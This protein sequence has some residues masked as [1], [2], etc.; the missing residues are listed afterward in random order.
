MNILRSGLILS[1]FLAGLAIGDMSFARPAE[2]QAQQ[3]QQLTPQFYRRNCMMCHKTAVPEG[4]DPSI[5]AGVQPIHP[6]RSRDVMPDTKCWRRCE[7]CWPQTAK[8]QR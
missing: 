6:T 3:A 5:V 8:S 7:K 2:Q 4:L 1:L